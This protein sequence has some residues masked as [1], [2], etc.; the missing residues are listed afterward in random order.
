M[1]RKNDVRKLCHCLLHIYEMLSTTGEG[2]GERNR[3]T[4]TKALLF[5]LVY[6]KIQVDF[7]DTL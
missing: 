7:L 4:Q 5:T 6:P 2:K 1:G 3:E